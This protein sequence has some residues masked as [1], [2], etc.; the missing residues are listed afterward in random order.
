MD[1]EPKEAR[2]MGREG[3]IQAG[4]AGRFQLLEGKEVQAL[5]APT[6]LMAMLN[7]SCFGEQRG[8]GAG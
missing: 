3:C 6:A 5:Y 4:P 2:A 7:K 8:D 1:L